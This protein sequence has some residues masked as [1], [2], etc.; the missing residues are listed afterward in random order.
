MSILVTILSWNRRKILKKT[1]DSFMSKHDGVD[2]LAWDNGSTDGAVEMLKSRGIEVM[3]SP[4]NV[5]IFEGTKFMWMEANDRGYEF[6]I[7]LQNDFPCIRKIPLDDM[8]DY[9]RANEDVGFVL[10]NDK[11]KMKKISHTGRVSI[12]TRK[13]DINKLTGEKIRL[14]KP[15]KVGETS[16]IKFNHHF[17]FNPTFVRVSILPDIMVDNPKSRERGIMEGFQKTKLS[18]AK[19]HKHYF[20]TI[21]RGRLDGWI[22]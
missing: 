19:S 8:V 9:M 10:L 5:G 7:N 4:S 11:R 12:K 21:L 13:C 20:E 16:F 15:K 18:A 1:V 22:H 3:S 17:T 14:G 2:Y 6:V